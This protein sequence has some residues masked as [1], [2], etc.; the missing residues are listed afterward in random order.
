MSDG[1]DGTTG[2]RVRRVRGRGARA[3]EQRF[4]E[5]PEAGTVSSSVGVED[6][7][8]SG[9]GSDSELGTTIEEFREAARGEQTQQE[10][11]RQVDRQTERDVRNDQPGTTDVV[12]EF[13]QTSAGEQTQQEAV[14]DLE[15]G[16]SSEPA[17]QT[18]TEPG[19]RAR[20]TIDEGVPDAVA[21]R[22]REDVA[23]RT[24]G[25]EPGQVD[26]RRTDGDVVAAP[27][28][29]AQR[30]VA[31]Q[32][33]ADDATLRAL[34]GP[35]RVEN[36]SRLQGGQT[37]AEAG[38]QADAA[39]VEAADDAFVPE[40]FSLSRVDRA[41]RPEGG[42]ARLAGGASAGQQLAEGAP[43]RDRP[44]FRATAS[45]DVRRRLAR[46]QAE[47][48][49]EP[50]DAGDEPTVEGD[51]L[52][53]SDVDSGAVQ[54]TAAGGG[55]DLFATREAE[56]RE[57]ETEAA[58]SEAIG[59]VTNPDSEVRQWLQ[60]GA[61]LGETVIRLQG[62]T[63][64]LARGST[65][66]SP[67]PAT[68]AGAENPRPFSE[69]V[70][71]VINLPKTADSLVAGGQ[72]TNYVTDAVAEGDVG[73]TV[74]RT[75]DVAAAGAAVGAAS[76]EAAVES[77]ERTAGSFVAGA[78]VGAGAAGAVRGGAAA[79]RRAAPSPRR[80]APD[81]ADGSPA[82]SQSRSGVPSDR[83]D[84]WGGVDTSRP[85]REQSRRAPS[86][87]QQ[88]E[89]EARMGPRLR[90]RPRSTG[91]QRDRSDEPGEGF[92]DVRQAALTQ[93]QASLRRV[94]REEAETRRRAVD[95]ELDPVGGG[96][97][98]RA[99]IDPE[100][101]RRVGEP[102]PAPTT[103]T[104]SPA[105]RSGV[106]PAR[107]D[108]SGGGASGGALALQE[109]A[110][111]PQARVDDDPLD[112]TEE[113][114]G[115][116]SAE[117]GAP[118]FDQDFRSAAREQETLAEVAQERSATDEDVLLGGAQD[119]AVDELADT[120][121]REQA[122]QAE[123]EALDTAQ[124]PVQ[125][126]T[127]ASASPTPTPP[128]ASPAPSVPGVGA[129]GPGGR[130]LGRPRPIDDGTPTD[131]LGLAEVGTESRGGAPDRIGPG[132]LAET[133]T[134]FAG[135]EPRSPG[136]ERLEA[137]ATDVRGAQEL[138]TEQVLEGDEDV[139]EVAEFFGVGGGDTGADGGGDGDGDWQFRGV[140]S[141]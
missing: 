112:R 33:A 48:R 137:I 110:Q 64:G 29:G 82:R 123:R 35:T 67:T 63:P 77:P 65:P 105:P 115:V 108:A 116:T 24:A 94:A 86:A 138:P 56:M 88:V 38:R 135:E 23:G 59:R 87:G 71:D 130:P 101:G 55:T 66:D 104:T 80:L 132:W 91:R 27:S 31:A 2:G 13:R 92:E 139:A 79:A 34:G 131:D 93:N 37:A 30:A 16:T 70:R 102:A 5:D 124:R 52:A 22:L 4:A 25:V 76:A 45:E 39:R 96:G 78:A 46:Q 61:D 109:I 106:S 125:A 1:E 9:G 73:E 41:A 118:S 19:P 84:P 98:P 28:P 42:G 50:V 107:A 69:G 7:G 60:Y 18:A 36:P 58:R 53:P 127:P 134:R 133:F 10:A 95:P 21:E 15:D 75:R 126:Q 47:R 3:A 128:Q 20:G 129:P 114:L 11:V 85:L 54:T 51:R 120:R 14:E 8:G 43:D 97:R 89:F 17:G 32:R 99:A 49:L 100:T 83:P 122:Q 57:A 136:R 26:V 72:A 62:Q 68:A 81:D 103:S 141:L 121:E 74:S 12:E 113:D 90:Q 44:V 6:G 111:E 117:A 140:D 40:D 119:A